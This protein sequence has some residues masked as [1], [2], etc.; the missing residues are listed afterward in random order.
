ML[1]SL[2]I[3]AYNEA[4][5]IRH[6]LDDYVKDFYPGN[7]ELVVVLNGCRDN[8]R[9]VVEQA[10]RE[11]GHAIVIQE[12]PQGGKGRAIKYGFQHAQGDLIGF[13]DADGSTSPAEY[14]KLVEAILHESYDGAIASRWVRGS[15][16]V[17]RTTFLR[18]LFSYGFHYF[19][20]MLF[21]LP[22]RDTQCGAKLF[23]RQVV[24]QI[25]DKLTI[26]DMSIDIDILV[27]LKRAKFKIREVP[28]VWVDRSSAEMSG[29]KLL[30]AT[31]RMIV[32]LLKIRF[33]H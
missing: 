8:T 28:T 3:P 21:W 19:T 13:L 17:G 33:S 11:L 25:V 32:S 14:R 7:V 6:T 18:T 22:Y 16:V 15:R 24:E 1:I 29:A 30:R 23:R 5:R 9:E 26:T 31:G 27:Q 12:L 20:K 2:I 4:Q 10:Q